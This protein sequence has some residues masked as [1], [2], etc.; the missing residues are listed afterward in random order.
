MA[1]IEAVARSLAERSED[2]LIAQLGAIS[3]TAEAD[4]SAASLDSIE[5]IP[6]P[7]GA[8]DELFQA[9]MHVFSSISP[10]LSLD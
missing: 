3:Q 7:R 5:Y 1:E 6:V 8:F 4:S 9:G 2:E 10:N